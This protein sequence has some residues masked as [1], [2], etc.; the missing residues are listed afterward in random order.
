[1]NPAT[2]EKINVW[3]N[4]NYDAETKSIIQN[5]QTENP[6]DLE[7]SFYK[8]LRIWYWWIAWINGCWY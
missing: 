7:D 4:G 5:L 2:S 6:A 8:N 1:M 3:L